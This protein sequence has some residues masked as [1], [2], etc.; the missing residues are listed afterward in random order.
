MKVFKSYFWFY[1]APPNFALAGLD[2]HFTGCLNA[3]EAALHFCNRRLGLPS[4]AL[5]AGRSWSE[6]NEEERTPGRYFGMQGASG[7]SGLPP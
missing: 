7:P 6:R 1:A 5:R 2:L 4:C 3:H